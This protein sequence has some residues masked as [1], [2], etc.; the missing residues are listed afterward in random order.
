VDA[1]AEKRVALVIGN[2]DYQNVTR[3]ANPANDA[4]A[5]AN[6]FKAAG[7]DLV[8]F[9]RDLSASN[10]RRA[11]REFSRQTS[12]ADI[13][14]VF[15]A[16]HGIE[17]NGNNYLIPVDAKLE[18]DIDVEDETVSLD[19]V[20]S[21]IDP[22]KRLRLVILDACRDNPFLRTMK[23][24][25]AARSIGRGLAQ[26]EPATSN[27]LIAFAAKA[28]SIAVDGA[29][30]NS[31][32]TTA[33]LKHIAEPGLDLRIAFGLIRDEVIETTD[34]KQEPFV[35]GSLGGATVSLVP[36]PVKVLPASPSMADERR[37]YEFAE[38]V[39]TLE[40]WDWFLGQYSSG[41]YAKLAGAQRAKLLAT[42]TARQRA[43]Q[44]ATRTRQE[45]ERE[46][47]QRRA[48]AA[49]AERQRIER[50][51]AE[52]EAAAR[53]REEEVQRAKAA[54][55]ERQSIERDKA[56]GE[57]AKRREGEEQL[58][59]SAEKVNEPREAD[60]TTVAALPPSLDVARSQ[61]SNTAPID[62]AEIA[63]LLQVQLKRV[64]CNPG[65][66]SGEW[67]AG[68]RR[69]LEDFNK[70]A[71]S[72]LKVEVASLDALEAVRSK[73]SRVCPLVCGRGYRVQGE[74][75]I[76]ITCKAGYVLSVDGD[77]E[78]RQGKAVVRREEP[79]EPNRDS[80]PKPPLTTEKKSS[81][82]SG[83][84][85]I[86]PHYENGKWVRHGEGKGRGLWGHGG[87]C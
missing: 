85:I 22:A 24:S 76:A 39:A 10:I 43:E 50:D 48:K 13:A 41:F 87:N 59:K 65:T 63:R 62:S 14:V 77:C 42:E 27:T 57:A 54:E 38:K 4:S 9:R 75:C 53:R 34:R 55:S 25:I 45:E 8:D 36:A 82:S 80:V 74:R 70:H 17:L 60:K 21:V 15:Y 12:D 86:G 40:A 78:K 84:C 67:G 79:K 73:A 26:V 81:A 46:Q 33:V 56:E 68:S 37:E 1:L 71:G 64:G 61:R 30:S 7:F 2:S 69:A 23:R 6:L 83:N 11:I 35:Y 29:G 44:E 5:I 18:S 16:G 28:G 31:P 20:L 52:R 72:K 47:E 51:K 32:F 58:A 3:L 19:R 49:D 66:Q